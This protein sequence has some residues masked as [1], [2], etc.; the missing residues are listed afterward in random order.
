MP[1]VGWTLEQHAAVK[2]Y[3]LFTKILSAVGVILSIVFILSGNMGGWIVLGMI[4]CIYGA[5]FLFIR[6]KAKSQ[7]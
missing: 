2:R 5:A 6:N 1:H 3:M 7:P 4:V